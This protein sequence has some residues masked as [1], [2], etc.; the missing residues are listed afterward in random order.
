MADGKTYIYAQQPDEAIGRLVQEHYLPDGPLQCR[1][2]VSSLHDNYLVEHGGRKFMLRVYR[3]NW[4]STSEALF[5]LELLDFLQ[6]QQA[7]VAGPL[8]TRAGSLWAPLP[9]IEGQR[10]A[11]LFHYAEGHAPE[12]ALSV[13]D[14][15]HLGR[16]VAAV[17]Q[18]AEGFV[19]EHARPELEFAH[20]VE[21]PVALFA[22]HLDAE[23]RSYLEGLQSRLRKHWPSLPR[24]AG[25]YGPCSGDINNRNFHITA[26]H[27]VTLFDFDQCGL[28]YR[29][30]EIGKFASS[31]HFHARKQ[32]LLDAFLAGYQALRRLSEDEARAIPVYEMAAVIWVLG[33]AVK[34]VSRIGHKYMEKPYWGRKIGIL[35]SLEATALE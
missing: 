21:E 15:R 32:E 33:I 3:A 11:A 27:K 1:F 18:A 30:F 8:R 28:G 13:D 29:A 31:I 10:M 7:P 20:L 5:E 16:A 34:N 9:S 25:V 12:G 24:V 26:G 35:K 6:R 14:C 17:H 22:P 2:Y 19:T 4:R 23:A